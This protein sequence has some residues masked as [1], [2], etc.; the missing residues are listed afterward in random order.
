MDTMT[1]ANVSTSDEALPSVHRCDRCPAHANV[2]AAKGDSILGF[3]RH[4]WTENKDALL[5][6]AE[7]VV[8][9]RLHPVDDA[10]PVR[11]W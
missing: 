10:D 5:E 2:T 7:D 8:V 4:H 1:K 9:W 3:C 11:T 6:W